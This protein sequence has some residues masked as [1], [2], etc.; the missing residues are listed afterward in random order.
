MDDAEGDGTTQENGNN[1][2]DKIVTR[3]EEKGEEDDDEDHVPLANSSKFFVKLYSFL[4]AQFI[5]IGILTFLGF[6]YNFD[7]YFSYSSKAF[8]WTVSVISVFSLISS[9]IP[10]CL[11]DKGKAGCCSYFLM[12]VYIPIITIYCY[13]L[14]KVKVYMIQFFPSLDS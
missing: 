4:L 1:L 14:K 6:Y 5:L 7:D 8:W 10:I 2:R 3:N 11:A 9:A 13:L 12:I